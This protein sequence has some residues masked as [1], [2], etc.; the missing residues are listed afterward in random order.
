[1][2][3]ATY[4]H[5]GVFMNRLRDQMRD[6]H[7]TLERMPFF[8]ALQAGTL[9]VESYV[10]LLRALGVIHAALE[11]GLDESKSA[12]VQSVWH[13]GL[14]KFALLE[15]DLNFF[16]P[17][18]IPDVV[19][20]AQAALALAA[21]IRL[22]ASRHDAGLLGYLYVFEGSTRGSV[23]IRKWM[24]K[25][26]RLRPKEGLAYFSNYGENVEEN[27]AQFVVRMERALENSG[28]IDAV[29]EGASAAY[30]GMEPILSAL[31]PL[32]PE[33]LR[34]LSST[35]NPEAGNHPIPN[36]PVERDAALRASIISMQ[37]IPYCGMRYGERGKRFVDSDSAWLA[38]LVDYPQET[39]NL[40]IQWLG[41]VLASR[42][43]PRWTLEIHLTALAEALGNAKPQRMEDY[44]KLRTAALRLRLDRLAHI[45]AELAAQI[46]EEFRASAPA[47][48]VARLP[49]TVDLIISAVADEK[50]GMD[51]AVGS[52][53]DW[54]ADASRFPE[55]WVDAVAV[56]VQ[57]ART[58]GTGE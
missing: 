25:A 9:P 34:F 41:R 58:G 32:S 54:L 18:Q 1:M 7:D 40:Q 37:L 15:K 46:A 17:R 6:R 14:K 20:A 16:V 3:E 50:S 11:R 10:G 2:T 44:E 22:C 39:V 27:W 4:A 48:W 42:G 29:L 28:E 47:E 36:D 24:E 31:Y 5:G 35:L 55:A 38:T 57:G 45:N 33:L 30:T 56:A 49:E 19:H 43:M 53:I 12:V 52:L 23:T 13:D 21:N 51:N 26:M 8:T